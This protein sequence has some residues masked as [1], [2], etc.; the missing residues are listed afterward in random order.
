LVDC[1]AN[2]LEA[3]RMFMRRRDFITLLSGAAVANPLVA[4][5]Q[6]PGMPV[7]GFLAGGSQEMFTDQLAKFRLGLGETGWTE[8]QNVRVEYRWA[9]GKFDRLPALAV[10]LVGLG[11][12]AIAATGGSA[13]AQAAKAA[14][15]TIP[16]VFTSGDD[17]VKLGFVAALNHPGGNMTGASPFT[18]SLAPKRLQL[19]R[20]IVPD[21]GVVAFLLDPANPTAELQQSAAEAAAKALGLDMPVLRAGA[22]D[23]FDPAFA[24][25]DQQRAKALLVG[26]SPFFLGG[27]DKLIALC[28]RHKIPAIF[29]WREMVVAGGLFSYGTS[30]AAAYRQMAVYI[31]R[32]LHGEKPADLPVVQPSVFELIVNLKTAKTLGIA[33]PTSLLAEADEVI[34]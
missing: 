31:G 14:T 34:D 9:Q 25:L 28:A 18:G 33:L 4:D 15:K 12:A 16:I 26:D 6:Q 5:A 7:I 24:N 32:V 27:R 29:Q 22:E 20:E 17:P 30:L 3:I 23:E 2:L 8:G 11:V 13:P 1:Q 21:A 19:L 10:E